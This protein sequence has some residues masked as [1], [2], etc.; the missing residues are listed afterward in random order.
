MGPV[1]D[2]A[3]MASSAPLPISKSTSAPK[4]AP[5]SVTQ[6]EAQQSLEELCAKLHVLENDPYSSSSQSSLLRGFIKDFQEWT[7]TLEKLPTKTSWK[8]VAVVS[9]YLSLQKRCQTTRSLADLCS[10]S[11]T[12]L[13]CAW[14]LQKTMLKLTSTSVRALSP[15]D[16]LQCQCGYMNLDGS[17]L[18]AMKMALRRCQTLNHDYGARTLSATI[19]YLYLKHHLNRPKITL[20]SIAKDFGVC[21]LSLSRFKRFLKQKS[22]DLFGKEVKNATIS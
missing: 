16:V 10:A 1:Y 3:S 11:Q 17:D 14:Q 18:S 13:K 19:C 5:K 20:N 12:S 8:D 15:E 6:E 2:F 9:L 7:R 4:L 22:L 21:S